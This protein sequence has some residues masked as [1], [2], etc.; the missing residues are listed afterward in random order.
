MGWDSLGQ[1]QGGNH[2][3][4]QTSGRIR[5]Q[6]RYRTS[7]RTVTGNDIRG[8]LDRPSLPVALVQFQSHRESWTES[9]S[10][11]AMLTVID[12]AAGPNLIREGASPPKALQNIDTTMRVANLRCASPHNLHTLGIVKRSVQWGSKINRVRFV[13]V[14]NLWA[15]D[16][17]DCSYTDH[18]VVVI[19]CI[20]SH[21]VLENG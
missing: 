14:R 15:D 8:V 11:S 16:L 19:I 5:W 4:V 9:K 20:K 12:T 17:L 6:R 13:V 3:L 10:F 7:L 18:Y 21:I 1:D 2:S